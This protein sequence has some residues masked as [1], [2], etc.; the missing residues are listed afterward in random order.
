L[1]PATRSLTRDGRL[2]H[3]GARALDILIALIE[4]A[5]QVVSNAELFAI[6]WPNIF[7]EESALRVP[8]SA[9]HKTH[10]DGRS[11]TRFVL[12]VRGRAYT[13]LAQAERIS[14]GGD[15]GGL[16]GSAVPNGRDYIPVPLVRIIG[17]D[18][19]VSEINGAMAGAT[20]VLP[21]PPVPL[22]VTD[23][24]DDRFSILTKA[25]GTSDSREQDS[26]RAQS[27]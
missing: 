14:G 17:R 10:G 1:V 11:G 16:L 12:S 19:I 26:S 21:K 3:L 2:V 18:E 25:A 23:R 6:V 22:I 8:I 27:V 15:V 20:A 9:L 4:R 24:L 7:I 5:R 13:F